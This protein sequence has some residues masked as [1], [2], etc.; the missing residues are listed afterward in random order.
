[1]N[2]P[3]FGL[4]LLHVTVRADVL[5]A[6]KERDFVA[7]E[8]FGVVQEVGC[9]F[10]DFFDLLANFFRVVLEGFGKFTHLQSIFSNFCLS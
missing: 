7:K 6:G 9:Q 5:N 3:V 1:M 4:I 2:S 8:N 10:F